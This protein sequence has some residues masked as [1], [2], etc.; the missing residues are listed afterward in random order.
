LTELY[1]KAVANAFRET[2]DAIA[3]QTNF[4]EAYL[5]QLARE[6]A[7]DRTAQLA[8]IRYDN[9]AVSLFDVLD[10]ERQLILARLESIDAER[11]RATA[12]VD[13][14]LALGL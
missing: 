7:L 3:S 4:R 6:R 5:A 9:G 14:Y 10:T 2:R 1:Q 12:I 11:A 8:K 13:L